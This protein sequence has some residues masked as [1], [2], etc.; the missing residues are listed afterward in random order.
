MSKS[1]FSVFVKLG[2]PQKPVYD[3]DQIYQ[4]Y[5]KSNFIDCRIGAFPLIEVPIPDFIF[6]DLDNDNNSKIL[7]E[8]KLEH[9]LTNINK[10][11]DGHPTVLWT[12]N[13]FHIYQPFDVS[14]TLSEID[15]FKDFEEID[16]KFLQFEKDTYPMDMQIRKTIHL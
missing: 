12:G 6:I 1:F 9:T 7:L 14:T 4:E 16:N 8:T 5:E 11:L 3:L 2:G 13:G 10:R 15:G